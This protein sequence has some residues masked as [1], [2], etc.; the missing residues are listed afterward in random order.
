MRAPLS[1]L[2]PARRRLLVLLLA[3]V[4]V[5]CVAGA[6]KLVI[7]NLAGRGIADQDKPGPVVLVPGY[8]G[9]TASLDP[10]VAELRRQGRSTVVAQPTSGGTGDLRTQAKRLA[11]LVERTIESSG[12]DSVDLVGYSA[13][14]VVA[15]L[16]VRDEDGGSVVRRVLTLG[17]PQHGTDVAALA[18]Q[19]AGGCPTACEQ[20]APDSDVLRRLNAGDETLDGPQWVTVRTSKDSVVTP[21]DSAELAGALNIEVQ[22]LCPGATTTHGGL[23]GDPVVL[24]TVRSVLGRAAPRV[25]GDVTC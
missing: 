15:R 23:P 20:L 24:A 16:Y 13:G 18:A 2:A 4:L 25:P 1:G 3:G 14:G 12:S 9:D 21:P 22:D 17:S 6:G 19:L 5:A 8:G 10:L 11:T 7:D